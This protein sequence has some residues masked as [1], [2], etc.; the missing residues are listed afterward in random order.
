MGTAMISLGGR[1]LGGPMPAIH[2]RNM[3]A[4]V[5]S[6]ML[7]TGI[8]H[9]GPRLAGLPPGEP[10][11]ARRA[12]AEQLVR[13][14]QPDETLALRFANKLNALARALAE[15]QGRDDDDTRI[16]A[17]QTAEQGIWKTALPQLKL[18]LVEVY[19]RELTDDELSQAVAFYQTP[20]GNALVAAQRRAP[21]TFE[22]AGA[23]F[24]LQYERALRDNFCKRI[25]CTDKERS[26]VDDTVVAK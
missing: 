16:Q 19:A 26:L 6:I 25:T 8:A 22:I 2:P 11:P 12:L 9:A 17:A 23:A 18:L 4:V 5:L 24:W 20:A 21:L 10:T 7:V 13:L 3:A 1:K 15:A 14:S